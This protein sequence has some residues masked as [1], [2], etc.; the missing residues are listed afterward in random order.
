MPP[1]ALYQSRS[2]GSA[3]CY[4][5]CFAAGGWGFLFVC[6]FMFCFSVCCVDFLAA[7]KVIKN[8]FNNYINKN[9]AN[10]K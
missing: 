6:F 7:V 3:R 5:C 10:G 2:Y 4:Y 8:N 9:T 1:P